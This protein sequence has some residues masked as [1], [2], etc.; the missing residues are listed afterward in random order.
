MSVTNEAKTHYDQGIR[1][2]QQYLWKGGIG[3]GAY[4]AIRRA[5]EEFKTALKIDP[6]FQLA[7]LAL[8]DCYFC[9]PSSFDLN[10]FDAA[11]LYQKAIKASPELVGDKEQAT[12]G[13]RYLAQGPNNGYKA[14]VAYRK[15]LERKPVVWR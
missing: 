13:D 15:A 3:N 2:C 1:F 11:L 14:S 8:A 9:C 12:L 6:N 10:P 7:R 5:M 4:V